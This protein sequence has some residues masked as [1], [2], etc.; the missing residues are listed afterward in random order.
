MDLLPLSP[1]GFIPEPPL[2]PFI[3]ELERP[4]LPPPFP[5]SISH[6]IRKP[7]T[8]SDASD[9]T[10]VSSDDSPTTATSDDIAFLPDAPSPLSLVSPPPPPVTLVTCSGFASA[11][12]PFPYDVRLS[13]AD[14]LGAVLANLRIA[15]DADYFLLLESADEALHAIPDC[16]EALGAVDGDTLFLLKKSKTVRI[17][18]PNAP[19]R[20]V[21]LD[22]SLKA[23]ALL[24]PVGRAFGIE[25]W[26]CYRL[27]TMDDHIIDPDRLVPQQAR[28]VK[29]LKCVRQFMLFTLEDLVTIDSARRAFREAMHEFRQNEIYLQEGQAIEIAAL[30]HFA[31]SDD[32]QMADP[33]QI[34]EEA[35]RCLPRTCVPGRR[36]LGKIL[37]YAKANLR[38]LDQFTAIKRLLK[39]LRHLQGFCCQNF[40]SHVVEVKARGVKEQTYMRIQAGPLCIRFINPLNHVLEERISYS[41][42]LKLGLLGDCLQIQFSV[43]SASQLCKYKIIGSDAARIKDV[44]D[45]Y[46]HV[47]YEIESKR[48]KERAQRHGGEI[49]GVVSERNRLQL[50]TTTNL[51]DAN[52]RRFVYD[53]NFTGKLFRQAVEQNLGVPYDPNHVLLVRMTDSLFRWVSDDHILRLVHIQ[54]GM[55]VYLL[56]NFRPISVQFADGHTD[57]IPLDITKNV[58]DL[59]HPIFEYETLPPLTG[60]T[61]FT[62]DGDIPRPLDTRYSIPEQCKS[63]GR[64][65]FKRRFWVISGQALA[66]P[67]AAHATVCDCR[68][69][70][71]SGATRVTEDE[72]ATL[73]VLALYATLPRAQD[74]RAS[75]ID[76]GPHIPANMKVT[77]KLEKNFREALASMPPMEKFAAAKSYL[78]RVRRIEGFGTESFKVVYTDVSFGIAPKP[79]TDVTTMVGPYMVSF[80][81]PSKQLERIPYK[82]LAS[83]ETMGHHLTLRF[84]SKSKKVVTID[85]K[86]KDISTVHMLISHNI[87]I[88]HELMI[89]KERACGRL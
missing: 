61:L 79:I 11:G 7:G 32:P 73:A 14:L 86:A 63:W 46:R 15:N 64:L 27:A 50:F 37:T 9:T 83:F 23:R 28:M 75:H 5:A 57:R 65:L 68:D 85:L 77:R 51:S 20:G 56:T 17:H 24:E 88:I 21:R 87:K 58:E 72:A 47:A 55:T 48:A 74:L 49:L 38:S 45:G 67:M 82:K 76:V 36:F 60:Y 89:E 39:I 31:C 59:T 41:K 34:T 12:S 35:L 70:V 6:P 8:S 29:D 22:L 10:P 19:A 66:N 80:C 54:N 43:A 16:L 53:C 69:L 42:I 13:H 18:L 52:P 81:H 3:P 30:Y 40:D 62:F 4:F 78:G 2:L 26:F 33:S 25:N 71:L 84:V 44:I 1:P